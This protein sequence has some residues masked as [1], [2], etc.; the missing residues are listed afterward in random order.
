MS[1]PEQKEVERLAASLDDR[2]KYG[3]HVSCRMMVDTAAMLRALHAR[4]EAL[5]EDWS[6]AA[7]VL[8]EDEPAIGTLAQMVSETA[9]SLAASRLHL[10]NEIAA[11]NA[12]KAAL[13]AARAE[14]A[15]LAKALK[16]FADRVFNDN[17]DMAVSDRHLVPMEAFCDAYLA[18]R[19]ALTGEAGHG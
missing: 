6:E 10:R 17:G 19:A 4:A 13:T 1:N 9:G 11:H 8:S 14:A 15:T 16:P 3:L 7:A 12:T 5:Q 2:A 18:R